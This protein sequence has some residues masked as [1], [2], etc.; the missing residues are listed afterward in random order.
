MP[1]VLTLRARP[2][3]AQ[4][5]DGSG[6]VSGLPGYGKTAK[7]KRRPDGQWQWDGFIDPNTGDWN[8]KGE[9]PDNPPPPEEPHGHRPETPPGHSSD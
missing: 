6:N 4:E 9:S 2:A 7:W 5:G 3:L 1:V 8:G